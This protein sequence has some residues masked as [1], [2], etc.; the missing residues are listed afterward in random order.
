[1]FDTSLSPCSDLGQA[2]KVLAPKL[3]KRT[4]EK[5]QVVSRLPVNFP[6]TR[7]GEGRGTPE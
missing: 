1:M 4:A 5:G 6:S 2:D 7:W 3:F